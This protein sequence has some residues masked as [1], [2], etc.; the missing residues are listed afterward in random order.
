MAIVVS[1][2][3]KW[4]VVSVVVTLESWI[5]VAVVLLLKL[6]PCAVVYAVVLAVVE[7]VLK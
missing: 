1:W 4:F 7:S 5:V 2:K 3:L 6:V